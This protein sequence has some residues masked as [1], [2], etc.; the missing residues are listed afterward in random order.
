[1]P[2]LTTAALRFTCVFA[3]TCLV[4]L[5]FPLTVWAQEARP[6]DVA[7]PEAVVQAS[8]EALIRKPGEPFDCRAIAFGF[9]PLKL[10]H[11]G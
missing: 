6:A 4:V 8:Y 7:S 5:L 10:G 2:L 1:M 3:M 9:L 11:P